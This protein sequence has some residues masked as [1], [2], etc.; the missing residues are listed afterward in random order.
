VAALTTLLEALG[1]GVRS[2]DRELLQ[3]DFAA[4]DHCLQRMRSRV[5]LSD[6]AES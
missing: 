1:S 6:D 5:G 4:M 3:A 2:E